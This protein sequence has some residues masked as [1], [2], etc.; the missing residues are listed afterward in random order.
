L[1]D[2]RCPGDGRSIARE[3]AGCRGERLQPADG[4]GPGGEES[5]EAQPFARKPV[6]V[7]RQACLAPVSAKEFGRQAFDGDQHDVARSALEGSHLQYGVFRYV[8]LQCVGQ[9]L[10]LH[11]QSKQDPIGF[12]LR[13]RAVEAVV[14]DL[15]AT[16]AA[17]KL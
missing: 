16:N 6:E 17:T 13:Q 12:R 14:L 11:A 5:R 7:G 9:G 10:S 8:G 15:V 1:R 2:A 4:P 3:R